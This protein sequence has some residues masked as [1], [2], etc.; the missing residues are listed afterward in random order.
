MLVAAGL[1]LLTGCSRLPEDDY[2]YKIQSVEMAPADVAETNIVSAAKAEYT[3]VE[4][5][6]GE[7]YAVEINPELP[8]SSFDRSKLKKKKEYY[9]YG[10]KSGVGVDVST[11]QNTID[12]KKVADSGIDFAMIRLGIRG[13]KTGRL[14]L[15]DNFR[16][17]IKGAK[18]NGLRT[19]V[20]FFSQA[21]SREEAEEEAD[22]VLK[23]LKKYKI[24]GPVALDSELI[25]SKNARTGDL[26]REERTDFCIAFC[27]RIEEA[28]YTPMIYADKAQLLAELDTERLTDYMIWY[29]DFGDK[30]DYPY[31]FALWQYTNKGKVPGIKGNVDLNLWMEF[32]EE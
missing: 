5:K 22:F 16:E 20:Y 8:Q 2:G 12:W 29:S 6:K 25:D 3:Y 19:G 28:G 18:K 15:D 24:D 23:A 4:D 32:N 14:V 13:Y 31:E 1:V 11:F 10:K 27:E 30:P 9:S 26:T 17:N 7:E 21:I